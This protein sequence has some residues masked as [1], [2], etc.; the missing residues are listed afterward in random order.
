MHTEEG[1]EPD[2]ARNPFEVILDV[3]FKRKSSGFS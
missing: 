2:V 3:K 1:A